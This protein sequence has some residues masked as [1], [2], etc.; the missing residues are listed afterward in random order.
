MLPRN[1][2]LRYRLSSWSGSW[3]MH[4]CSLRTENE[5]CIWFILLCFKKQNNNWLKTNEEKERAR[6][7]VS[8]CFWF[9]LRESQKLQNIKKKW[10]AWWRLR[11]AES[12][13]GLKENSLERPTN[14]CDCAPAYCGTNQCLTQ[15]GQKGKHFSSPHCED[16]ESRSTF[17]DGS[18]H[19]SRLNLSCYHWSNQLSHLFSTRNPV[20]TVS[21]CLRLGT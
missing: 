11:G 20:T 4:F 1:E 10:G 5:N 6:K 21:N 18:R 3:L 14:S 19:C 8:S 13:E 9:S 2:T 7:Q 15:Q 12:Y 16:L 17:P